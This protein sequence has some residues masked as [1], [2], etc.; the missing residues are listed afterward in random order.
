MS[1]FDDEKEKDW[2]DFLSDDARQVLEGLLASIK[3]HKG[4]YVQSDEV[5]IAQ[6][7][8]ALIEMKRELNETKEMLGKAAA[9]WQAIVEVGEAEKKKTIEKLVSEITKPTDTETQ[10]ATK[11]LV[12]SLMKF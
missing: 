10:E 6:L 9:P 11:K 3:K 7:W 5:K 8:T 12:E 4:A 1:F 2:K